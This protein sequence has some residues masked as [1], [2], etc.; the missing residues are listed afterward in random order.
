MPPLAMRRTIAKRP[1][2]ARRS[3]EI[4]ASGTS[5]GGA[6]TLGSARPQRTQLGAAARF[7]VPQS[8]QNMQKRV[9]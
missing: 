5:T 2:V 4:S 8:G 9:G 3:A 6:E 7:Q 1:P